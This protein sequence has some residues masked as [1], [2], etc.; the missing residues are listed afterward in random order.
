ME[1]NYVS[2]FRNN[3]ISNI[4]YIFILL[5][6]LLVTEKLE[7][8]TSKYGNPM[9]LIGGDKFS[10]LKGRS[11]LSK[12]RWVCTKWATGCRATILTIDNILISTKNFH[13][14]SNRSK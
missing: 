6:Y 7:F 3:L 9:I 10:L 13:N 2:V 4:S 1:S 12:K 8:I 14:H 11:Q 5:K